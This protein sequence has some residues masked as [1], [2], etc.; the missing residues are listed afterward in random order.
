MTFLNMK[1][2]T[3]FQYSHL[4]LSLSFSFSLCTL[5]IVDHQKFFSFSRSSYKGKRFPGVALE[6]YGR[7]SRDIR[8]SNRGREIRDAS[9]RG[10]NVRGKQ[11]KMED[12]DGIGSTAGKR[13]LLLRWIRDRVNLSSAKMP[14]GT[15]VNV[16]RGNPP[17]S[18]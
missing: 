16:L 12:K 4:T 15:R 11:G 18:L 1:S 10:E 13:N 3:I 5:Q 9:V 2:T 6:Q 17:R 7:L 14:R 8:S